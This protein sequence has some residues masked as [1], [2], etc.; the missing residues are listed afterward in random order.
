[1]GELSPL[2]LYL[3][4][5]AGALLLYAF[6]WFATRSL[7]RMAQILARVA[8]LALIPPVLLYVS[9]LGTREKVESAA[10]PAPALESRA[11][12]ARNGTPST[13]GQ[14]PRM[15]EAPPAPRSAPPKAAPPPPASAPPLQA[16]PPPSTA[17]LQSGEDAARSAAAVPGAPSAPEAEWDLVPVFYGTDRVRKEEAKRIAY[18]TE[19]ARRLELGHAL[20]TVPKSHQ[21]PNIERPFAI[22]IPYFEITIFEQ[23]E[24][25]KKHFTIKELKA[26]TREEF[27]ALARERI[28]GSRAFKDQAVVFVH[29]YNTAFDYALF[30]TAQMAYDLKFDGASFLYSWPSGAGFFGY[31]YDRDSA[32]QAQLYLKEF[33]A[34]VVEQSG[35]KSVSVIAHSMGNLP[36]LNVLRELGPTLPPSV[37]LN[38]IILAAPD[39]DRDVFVNLAANLEQYGRGVTL[40]ASANDR[41][42]EA[43]RRVAGGVPRAGDVPGDG[44]VLMPGIDTIDVTQAGTDYLALNHS[45]YAEK[46]A[47]LNDIGLLLRTGERPPDR[48]VPILQRITTPKGEFWRYPVLR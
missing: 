35:A 44:P 34:L 31:G 41:A 11:P 5:F 17:A 43:A 8:P 30:R 26:L 39:V 7:P 9:S 20:V 13:A 28:G 27:I 18:T 37:R 42:M 21:V 12:A 33:L 22:R 40:Y 4:A 16:A 1:M 15:A 24:D 23:A 29:G 25:P 6:I 45:L 32:T 10:R 36:L 38:Q 47:L 48:R 19:R 3:A 2:G 14:E 46:G